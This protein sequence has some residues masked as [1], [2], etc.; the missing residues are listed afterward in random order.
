MP[1]G[2]APETHLPAGPWCFAGR[3]ALFP[4][5]EERFAFPPEP[6]SRPE[7]LEAARDR[8]WALTLHYLPLVAE[9]LSQVQ[10]VKLPQAFWETALAPSVLIVAQMLAERDARARGLIEHLGAL[11]LRV[12]LLPADCAFSFASDYELTKKGFLGYTCN[13]WLFSLLLASRL[14][15]AWEPVMLP[16]V[17]EHH[18]PPAPGF[19]DRLYELTRRIAYA[20]PFPH[21]KGFSIAQSLRF[22]LALLQNR[23]FKDCSF[24]LE[25]AAH[26][27]PL[28]PVRPED[29]PFDPLPLFLTLLPYSIARARLPKRIPAA[30]RRKV[31]VASVACLEDGAYRL[32]LAR[33]RGAGHKLVYVQHGGNY[34][35]LR[36]AATTPLEEYNQHAF[37]TW[38]W[39]EQSPLRGN[40]IPLPH[41]Q[42][43]ALSDAHTGK[44]G[45][46]LFVGNGM[47]LFPHRLDSRPNPTQVIAYRRAKAR[48]FS[49]L[50]ADVRANT[51][52]RPYFDVPAALEDW[53]WVRARFPDLK[54]C[55]GSLDEAMLAC[56][57]LVLD[58]HGT[59]LNLALAADTPLLLYWDFHAWEL[60]PEAEAALALLHG[61]GIWHPTPEAAAAKLL[62]IWPDV[63]AFWH[64]PPVRKA[65]EFWL[66]RYALSAGADFDARWLHA[67]KNL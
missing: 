56:R 34:G 64:S 48:F 8:A 38:G 20:P 31:R 46:L 6:L 17:R 53:P 62:E 67:L 63:R 41:A 54:R 11:P 57:L 30:P 3:E 44:A 16:A 35:M 43:T 10:G 65:R 49:A 40:F 55:T 42:T 1:G 32:R 51:L 66:E 24:S 36:C 33:L 14:P 47:E 21:I 7:A 45:T 18:G 9:H 25:E 2:A 61:A 19:R 52:Y 60:C 39:T 59:T 26:C 58:H 23:S 50:P 29:L 4:G 27:R 12:P 13:H 5:W 22:S 28:P 15:A 37:V